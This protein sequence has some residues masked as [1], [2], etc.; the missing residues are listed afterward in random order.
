MLNIVI[1][2]T[3][4]IPGNFKKDNLIKKFHS[5]ILKNG[6]MPLSVMEDRVMEWVNTESVKNA[7]AGTCLTTDG[8]EQVHRIAPSVIV[9]MTF[10]SMLN[11]YV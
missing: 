4:C 5:V 7:R 11:T 8:A 1:F 10:I 3:F 9:I 2:F 6:A